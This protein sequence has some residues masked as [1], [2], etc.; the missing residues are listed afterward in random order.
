M[1]VSLTFDRDRLGRPESYFPGP[2]RAFQHVGTRSSVSRSF[3]FPAGLYPPEK[4]E[5]LLQLLAVEEA[6]EVGFVVALRAGGPRERIRGGLLRAG[7]GEGG[8]GGS[9]GEEAA[10]LL[11]LHSG[12]PPLLRNAA[13]ESRPSA[14]GRGAVL[15]HPPLHLPHRLLL[16]HRP[17]LPRR[18]PHRRRQPHPRPPQQQQH[19]PPPIFRLR[20]L[21]PRQRV[22]EPP[23]QPESDA[24]PTG[25]ELQGK[26]VEAGTGDNRREVV[27]PT[28]NNESRRCVPLSDSSNP[29]LMSDFGFWLNQKL[30]KNKI[31]ERE[32]EEE[33]RKRQGESQERRAREDGGDEE[34]TRG[35]RRRRVSNGAYGSVETGE[36]L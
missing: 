21:L 14:P 27:R 23:V 2:S 30:K 9:Q 16:P 1:H 3:V 11:P 26:P 25:V 15:P 34:K 29:V 19:Q 5:G 22:V 32:K 36:L 35:K 20:L 6:N 8:G 4:R 12:T 18:P 13:A 10:G 31:Y 33:E 7:E 28:D 24:G 17:R